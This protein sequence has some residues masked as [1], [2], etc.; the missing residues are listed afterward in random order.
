M[1]RLWTA[2]GCGFQ[3]AAV[4][5]CPALCSLPTAPSLWS[6]AST[7]VQRNIGPQ[8]LPLRSPG[9]RCHQREKP[10][11]M[12][13]TN[14]G[15]L[16]GHLSRPPLS[17]NVFI[18]ETS[19][20]FLAPVSAGATTVHPMDLSNFECQ[21]TRLSPLSPK[22]VWD[23]TQNFQGVVALKNLQKSLFPLTAGY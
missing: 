21:E 18:P 2:L 11:M 20:L 17:Q 5:G 15:S 22:R 3:A 16:P 12:S 10:L 1:L 8:V 19:L 14:T 4:Q 9:E 7:S 13:P 23:L 6:P